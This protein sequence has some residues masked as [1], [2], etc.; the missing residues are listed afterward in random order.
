M[1][2]DGEDTI[3]EFPVDERGEYILPQDPIIMRMFEILDYKWKVDPET[4]EKRWLEVIRPVVGICRQ[5]KRGCV[6]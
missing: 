1:K 3:H 4:S 5:T 6:C 2:R